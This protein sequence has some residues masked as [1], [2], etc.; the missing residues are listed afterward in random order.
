MPST[1]R[2]ILPARQEHI[3]HDGR[4]TFRLA[5][6]GKAVQHRHRPLLTLYI[7]VNDVFLFFKTKNFFAARLRTAI[8]SHSRPLEPSNTGLPDNTN[9][10]IQWGSSGE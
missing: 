4:G 5:K 6:K 7:C 1:I 10:P 9:N 2:S 3:V 8:I